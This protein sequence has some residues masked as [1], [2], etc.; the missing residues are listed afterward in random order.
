VAH[1]A[2]D[3]RRLVVANYTVRLSVVTVPV[4]PVETPSDHRR[5][6]KYGPHRCGANGEINLGEND[7]CPVQ[8]GVMTTEWDDKEEIIISHS[9]LPSILPTAYSVFTDSSHN[10]ALRCSWHE[11][12]FTDKI[13]TFII[14]YCVLLLLLINAN[15]ENYIKLLA[16]TF[17]FGAMAINRWLRKKC[18]SHVHTEVT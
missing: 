5:R 7:R 6:K 13:I 17:C 12:L 1:T 3:L 4:L 15:L 10:N 18:L 8:S 11:R 16:V 14:Y 9:L 2:P